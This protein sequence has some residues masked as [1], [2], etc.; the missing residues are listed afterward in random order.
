MAALACVLVALIGG[1]KSKETTSAMLHN[2]AGRPDLAIETAKQALEKDPND[3][4]AYFQLG[5]AYSQLDSVALAYSEF[6]KVAELDPKREQITNDNIQS[7]FAKHYN[8]GINLAKDDPSLAA[9]EFKMATLADPRQSRGFYSLAI[10]YEKMGETD[11]TYYEGAIAAFDQV[12]QLSSPADK[13]YIDALSHAGEIL[14]KTG[15]P[16]EAISR[17]TRLVEED[18]TN[19]RVIEKIGYD[20]LDLKDWQGA[21]VFLELSAQAR[22]KVGAD[23]FNLYYNIGVA[24]F[25]TRK[26][27]E[28]ALAKAVDYYQRALEIQ[29]DEPQ[30]VFNILVAYSS[31]Q[32]WRQAIAWGEK[33]VGSN[34]DNPDSWRLL[35][36][37]YNETG[38][39]A[40]ARE[41]AVRYEE[42]QK[43]GSQ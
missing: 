12:L 27:D 38:N 22:S 43:T 36:R 21:A 13:H 11:P 39:D 35:S 15:E 20:R 33:Y 16:E 37:A 19:Y 29:P 26:E 34:P 17:F 18:P 6:R 7:N 10:S 42:L 31:A 1:C 3:A 2:D 14:A 8:R 40:K 24:Y 28:Q 30:T 32:D 4:E 25:Q 5:V 41:C 23:D 9:P